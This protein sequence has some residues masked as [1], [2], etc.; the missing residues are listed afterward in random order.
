MNY[1]L[2]TI[3][4]EDLAKLTEVTFNVKDFAILYD[5]SSYVE[6]QLGYIEKEYVYT[7]YLIVRGNQIHVFDNDPIEGIIDVK[8]KGVGG[9]K[10]PRIVTAAD[11]GHPIVFIPIRLNKQQEPILPFDTS[12][13]FLETCKSFKEF[14]ATHGVK[15]T[16]LFKNAE[17]FE[18][19]ERAS[20]D[21]FANSLINR[22]TGYDE[23]AELMKLKA[24]QETIDFLETETREL[25]E[26]ILELEKSNDNNPVTNLMYDMARRIK[27]VKNSHN[28]SYW[29]LLNIKEDADMVLRRFRSKEK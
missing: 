22:L 5:Q 6:L 26:R 21:V 29:E 18:F 28:L 17:I 16:Y 25:N 10:A 7:T 1:E 24:R 15:Q 11:A 8:L 2:E 19:F 12:G 13:G 27:T 3:K 20:N 4:E 23:R 14:L 9:W